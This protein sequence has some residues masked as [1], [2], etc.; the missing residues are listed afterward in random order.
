MTRIRHIAITTQTPDDTAGFYRDVFGLR[1]VGKIDNDNAEGYYLTD[2]HI[3]LAILKFRNEALAGE[4]F[5]AGY[6]GIHHFGFQVDDAQAADA[7][8]RKAGSAP[9]EKVNAALHAGMGNAHGGL[10]V[11]MKYKGPDDVSQGGW[12]GTDD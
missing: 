10:N 5:G 7:K 8:L 9:L 6:S 2:G 4:Q 3:N 1:E 12:V 11:E